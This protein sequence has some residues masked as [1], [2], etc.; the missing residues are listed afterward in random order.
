MASVPHSISVVAHKVARSRFRAK[1]ALIVLVSLAA[2]FLAPYFVGGLYSI[3][4]RLQDNTIYAERYDEAA[5]KR[6]R[7]GMTKRR[8]LEILGDPLY[9]RRIPACEIWF[10][11][12][13]TGGE[14]RRA[15]GRR[16]H[17]RLLGLGRSRFTYDGPRPLSRL[18]FDSCGK[19]IRLWGDYLKLPNVVGGVSRE[20]IRAMAGEPTEIELQSEEQAYYYTMRGG[21]DS[22]RVRTILFDES[23]KV[24][25]VIRE[26]SGD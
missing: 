23:G 21:A 24:T 5:F 1:V 20:E 3:S 8:V 15:A 18:E 6:V 17:R 16:E 25:D 12:E 2:R 14:A 7:M 22:Y 10:Y 11:Y 4:L 13:G 26:Y 19:L 9:T